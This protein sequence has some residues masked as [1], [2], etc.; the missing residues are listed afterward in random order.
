MHCIS[1]KI[2]RVEEWRYGEEKEHRELFQQSGC[3]PD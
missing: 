1:G 3:I 2:D